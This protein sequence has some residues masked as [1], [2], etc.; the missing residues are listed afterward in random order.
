MSAAAAGFAL[1]GCTSSDPEPVPTIEPIDTPPA[2]LPAPTPPPAAVATLDE[3]IAEMLMVGF[4][5][6]ALEEA[7]PLYARVKVG[8][9]GSTVLFD[10]DAPSQGQVARNFQS[11]DQVA[12]LTQRLQNLAPRRM[13]ISTDQ[14]GGYVARL[15]PKWGF[16]YT[17]TAAAL[18]ARND[19]IYTRD[20]ASAMART[21][22]AAGI[23]LNLAPVV[24]VNVNPA[25]PI[26]A[27]YQRSFSSKPETVTRQAL[28]FIQGH[29]DAGVLTTLK[30]F[31]GH[32]SSKDDSHLGFVDVTGLWSRTELEPFRSIIAAGAADAVMTAHI[33]NSEWDA[34]YPATLSRNVIT[35][36][37]RD[38][39]K[40]KGVVITDDMQMGAIKQYYGFDAAI[41]L[42]IQAGADIIAI[43]NN[44]AEY[45]PAMAEKAFMAIRRAVTANRISEARIDE[46]Y[47]RVVSL[48]A[49][50]G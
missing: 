24:D 37:L 3:K 30:H 35:G 40:F 32:G 7:D 2:T 5:G 1:A 6:Y 16:P 9:V 18:G 14:E 38:E 48:K 47:S 25:N 49:R 29:H 36:I 27:E 26:I 28:A 10:Y 46:S 21:M 17:P 12:A 31:P 11:P 43:S 44:G 8:L 50:L 13:L 20:V 4:R 23:N 45:D 39:L 33:F 19:P 22:A 15:S 41:E 42:A 34:T